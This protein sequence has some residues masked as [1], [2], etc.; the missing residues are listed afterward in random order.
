MYAVSRVSISEQEKLSCI[1]TLPFI[2]FAIYGL[3]SG[4]TI[5]R[6]P[7]N[8]KVSKKC[9]KFVYWFTVFTIE[10]GVFRVYKYN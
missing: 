5:I 10:W 1:A 4:I 6:F 9:S 8:E 3:I 2:T 7:S